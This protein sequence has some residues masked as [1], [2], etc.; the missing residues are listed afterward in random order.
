VSTE[1]FTLS[2][3]PFTFQIKTDIALVLE[4]A[5]MIYGDKFSKESKDN[6]YIDYYLSVMKS[7]GLR[8]FYK[9]QARFFCD[10]REPF[11]P[12]NH[13]DSP[14]YLNTMNK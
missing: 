7:T 12:L 13:K 10:N 4:N 6:T 11:K 5:K 2:L 3:A 14:I 1:V 8:R 9:P